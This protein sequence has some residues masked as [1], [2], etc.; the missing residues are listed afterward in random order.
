MADKAKRQCR[1]PG[2]AGLSSA[3]YCD[4][5]AS[6]GKEERRQRERWRGSAASRGYDH[7]WSGPGGAREQAL[8]RDDYLCRNCA[9][10]YSRITPATEVHHLKKI[11]TH[12]HLRLSLPNLLSVCRDCHEELEKIAA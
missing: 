8:K 2:C 12:P 7:S 1:H 9:L 6:K 5:H 4:D 11:T 3:D 10:K